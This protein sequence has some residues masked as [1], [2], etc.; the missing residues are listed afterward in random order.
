MLVI[1]ERVGLLVNMKTNLA[2]TCTLCRLQLFDRLVNILV[3]QIEQNNRYVCLCMFA[4]NEVSSC[5]KQF[6]IHTACSCYRVVYLGT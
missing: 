5:A 6:A 2:L 1:A 3:Q 4:Q